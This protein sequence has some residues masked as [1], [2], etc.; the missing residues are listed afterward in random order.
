MKLTINHHYDVTSQFNLFKTF[1]YVIQ[2]RHIRNSRT[3]NSSGGAITVISAV[4]PRSHIP[5][6]YNANCLEGD[7]FCKRI[8][9]ILAI[10]KLVWE[11]ID[12]NGVIS[13]YTFAD[14][15]KEIIIGVE[16]S[17][18]QF[19]SA[20]Q[21]VNYILNRGFWRKPVAKDVYDMFTDVSNPG[22][23]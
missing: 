17:S 6:I 23:I 1:N 13:Y 2:V 19:K 7:Q 12:K 18:A 10:Q 3:K 22:P 14:G 16:S 20:R 8:G 5:R 21:E 9:V 15:G 4:S 11:L